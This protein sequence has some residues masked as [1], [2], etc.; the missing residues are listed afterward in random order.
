MASSN[1]SGLGKTMCELD[2]SKHVASLV[3]ANRQRNVARF[4]FDDVRPISRIGIVGAGVMG[5]IVAA[6]AVSHGIPVA[7]TDLSEE[8]LDRLPGAIEEAMRAESADSADAMPAK[9]ADLV[10]RTT[11][12]EDVSSCDLIVESIVENVTTKRNFYSVLEKIC[13]DDKLIVSNTSTLPIAELA[14]HFR[15]PQR[16][17]GL[18]YFPA[19]GQ[20][21]M[22]EV[23]PG[24][25][26]DSLTTASVVRYSEQVD[27][28]P[29]VVAD[30]RG[31]L[32]NRILMAY[33]NAGIRLALAGV[34]IEAIEAAAADFDM[35]MGPI[36]L[37]DEV[38][39]DVALQCGWSFSADSETLIVRTPVIVRLMKLKH[40]GRKA[41]RG[42]FIHQSTNEDERVGGI[43]P[44]ARE[45]LESQ[46][47]S[48]SEL[49]PRQTMSAITLPMII[50]ATKLLESG[51]AESAEQLDLAVMCGFGFPASRGGPLFWADQLGAARIV[52]ELDSLRHIGPH[53]E[54]TALLIEHAQN[55]LSFYERESSQQDGSAQASSEAIRNAS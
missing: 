28:I 41:G 2:A 51:R 30:G 54:P 12:L 10:T 29:I 34:D 31:F 43:N 11:N 42:F 7:I 39:L 46:I 47:E 26:T 1:I 20:R 6:S 18:H 9:V 13:P 55:N 32:V 44:K 14:A 36:R 35:I 25:K 27:R 21:K 15:C 53:L 48:R 37:Y 38:G 24:A 50:E 3:G 33:M 23:I 49:T 45:I 17:C 19:I 5:S 4:A 40:L 22:L 16:F 52:N 8:A